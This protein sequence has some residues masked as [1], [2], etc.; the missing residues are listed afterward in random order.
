MTSATSSTATGM[1]L[2]DQVADDYHRN[3]VSPFADAESTD[4]FLSLPPPDAISGT[5][6]DAG[7]GNGHLIS[8]LSSRVTKP[9]MLIGC[10][11]SE[12]MIAGTRRVSGSSAAVL[13]AALQTL[14]F[15]DESVD[16]VFS[17]NSLIADNRAVRESSAAELYRVL[18]TGGA[19]I[20][21]FPSLESYTEQFHVARERLIAEG[22]DEHEAIWQVYDEI[23]HRLF[24]PI[25]GYIT[26]EHTEI[27]IKLYTRWEVSRLLA[28]AG[29]SDPQPAPFTY[30]PDYC[31][32]RDLLCPEHGLYDWFVTVRKDGNS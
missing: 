13:Q 20:A 8:A 22:A 10:D 25:G 30:T 18:S 1:N 5:V 4:R 29:F 14:P 24:D 3:V 6:L 31:A 7:C 26:L 32:R 27:R 23:N 11:F 12:N 28:Q 2:W 16:T 17:V 19:L 9:C 21:L 15:T